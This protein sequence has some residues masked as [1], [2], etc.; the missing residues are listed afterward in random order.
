MGAVKTRL[1][2]EIGAAKATGFYRATTANLIRRLKPDPRW[3]LV[4]AVTPD[5]AASRAEWLSAGRVPQGQGEIGMRM[6]RLLWMPGAA[7]TVLIGSDIP[8]ICPAHIAEA[9]NALTRYDAVFAPAE[10]GGFWL[11]GVK[12]ARRLAEMFDNVR[13]SGPH[14]LADTLRNLAGIPVAL[15]TTLSDVDTAESYAKVRHLGSCVTLPPQFRL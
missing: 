15:T 9:L 11:V 13:W 12:R 14:A 2:R 10:D 4:L 5:R 8:A 6:E 3:R 7:K 1:A